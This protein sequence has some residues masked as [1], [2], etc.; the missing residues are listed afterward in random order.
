MSDAYTGEVTVGG[1]P[2][3]RDLGSATLVKVAVGPMSNNSYVITCAETGAWVL[4]DAAAEPQTLLALLPDSGPGLIVT[5]HR[6]QDHSTALLEVLARVPVRTAAHELDADFLPSA[7]DLRLGHGDVVPVG[8]LD[9]EVIHLGGHTPGSICLALA[10]SRGGIHLFTGDGLFPGGV[11]GTWGDAAAF[12][13]LFGHV[14][15]RLFDRFDDDTW[16]YPGHGADT[17]LGA[18]RPNLPEW[19]GRGW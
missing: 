11:G 6:H 9:L 1:G 10:D 7:P 5:T 17:S 2:Q 8:S 16:V 4:I 15:T 12:A 14:K 3:A 19:E 13:E 18:E